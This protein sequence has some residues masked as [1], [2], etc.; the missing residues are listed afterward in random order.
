MT[1]QKSKTTAELL[2]LLESGKNKISLA[3]ENFQLALPEKR[4]AFK[5]LQSDPSPVSVSAAIQIVTELN[6][7]TE[8][9]ERFDAQ[10]VEFLKNQHEEK[11]FIDHKDGL[12]LALTAE[13]ETA[14]APKDGFVEKVKTGLVAKI[15]QAWDMGTGRE[16]RDKLL[17]QRDA[18]EDKL[19]ALECSI[20]AARAAMLRFS[21][22]PTAQNFGECRNAISGVKSILVE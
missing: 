11:F 3:A 19:A 17:A 16:D 20:I 14:L 10:H 9:A 8:L 13:L 2:S 1:P 15:T 21:T 7:L 22:I 6:G 18:Q 12:V 5:S 4:A